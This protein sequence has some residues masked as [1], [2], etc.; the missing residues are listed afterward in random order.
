MARKTQV[1]IPP[2]QKIIRKRSQ[3]LGLPPGS[4]VYLGEHP[5][6][7]LKVSV[8]E[9]S[10]TLC[11]EYEKPTLEECHLLK[12]TPTITWIN[13]D[14]LRYVEDIK[15]LGE[16]LG[17]H[18]LVLEDILSA[19]Q[20][21][22]LEDYGDYLYM[23][24]RVLSYDE[25][26]LS[27]RSDQLSLVIG[28]NYLISLHD[29]NGDLFAPIK[30]R[31]KAGAGRIRKGGPDYLAY[32]ILD[33]VVDNYFLLLESIGE[34][35]EDLEQQLITNPTP[36]TLGDTHRLKR[37]LI[38]LRRSVWPLREVMSRLERR[39]S[40]LIQ[41]GM[42]LYLKD[43]YDHVIQVIDTIETFREMLSGMLDIYLSSV[44]N[45]LNEVMKVLTI[46]ATIFIPL[47]FIAGVYGMNFKH[48]PE[49]E[50]PYGYYTVMGV[51]ITLGL[52][53]LG[54]FWRKGWLGGR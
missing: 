41:E 32:A 23:V 52:G 25:P 4:L 31:L 38:I 12:E 34:T 35:I 1:K 8:L 27:V 50:H 5:D 2:A 33:L 42:Y 18:P 17:L 28:A 44:S 19:D 53:M 36:Q 22:K 6:K 10:D 15:N 51:M 9:Y 43:V 40:P 46:I 47:T 24:L 29:G 30:A 48:M 45:R 7:Q 26:A 13:V 14:G 11:E 39:E 3:K 16:C 37:D 54:I 21:P 20:R 49:L